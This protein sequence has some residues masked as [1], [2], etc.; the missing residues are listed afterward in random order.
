MAPKDTGSDRRLKENI[1]HVGS[2]PSGLPIYEFDYIRGRG[3]IGRYR[4]VMSDEIPKDAV[5]PRAINN[6]FDAVDYNKID[7]DFRRI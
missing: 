3:P 7:V 1:E 5:I 4:G 6:V 2:S